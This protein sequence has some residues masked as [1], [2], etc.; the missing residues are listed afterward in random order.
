MRKSNKPTMES[1]NQLLTTIDQ[2]GLMQRRML[3]IRASTLRS[4]YLWTLFLKEFTKVKRLSLLRSKM[5]K[6]SK[7]SQLA[8]L[9]K[10]PIMKKMKW[11][12]D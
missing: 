5:K 9:V 8:V 11:Y 7:E 2:E 3:L 1:M 6:K 12:T 4:K 10:I